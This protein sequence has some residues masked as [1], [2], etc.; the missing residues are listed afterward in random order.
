M[1]VT[2]NVQCISKKSLFTSIRRQ[3]QHVT[4][5]EMEAVTVSPS[6]REE[7]LWPI[8]AYS[9]AHSVLHLYE[10]LHYLQTIGFA[11]L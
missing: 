2:V 1:E 6:L 9:V 4:L 5:H 10:N 11:E 3:K 8:H 7:F